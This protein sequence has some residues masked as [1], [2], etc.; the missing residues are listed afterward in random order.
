MEKRQKRYPNNKGSTDELKVKK[1]VEQRTFDNQLEENNNCATCN[2]KAVEHPLS[3]KLDQLLST[4]EGILQ[5]LNNQSAV[6]LRH[7]LIDNYELREILKVKE[8]KFSTMKKL[9]QSYELDKKQYYL[10][11]EVLDIIRNN[12]QKNE[13]Q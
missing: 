10:Q 3:G 5:L 12:V 6:N 7:Q 1:S 4:V 11:A 13:K 8:T 9:F 2:L